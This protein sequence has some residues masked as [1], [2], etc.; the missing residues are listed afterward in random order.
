M[1]KIALDSSVWLSSILKDANFEKANKLLSISKKE[2]HL[3]CISDLVIAE[4]INVLIKSKFSTSQIIKTIRKIKQLSWVRISKFSST[5][6]TRSIINKTRDIELKS[7][8][9]LI[10][11]HAI[12]ER[13]DIF[14]TFDIKQGKTYEKITQNKAN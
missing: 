6:L 9:F 8:D 11:T 5:N 1:R 3:V 12:E 14:Y 10:I 13:V 4:I 2:N 7:L